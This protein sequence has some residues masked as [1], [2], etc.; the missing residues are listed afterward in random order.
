MI[1]LNGIYKLKKIKGISNSDNFDYKVIAIN[2]DRTIVGCERISGDDP[3]ERFVFLIE[4]LIDPDKPN[5]IYFGEVV[6][7]K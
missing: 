7:K 3:G 2:K 5:D 4:C 6:K 1:E